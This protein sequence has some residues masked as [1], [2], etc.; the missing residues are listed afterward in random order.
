MSDGPPTGTP[1]RLSPRELEV[2]R[3]VVEGLTNREI[4]VKLFLSERT[5]DG[6]LEHIR[7]KLGV[8]TRAQV[9]AWVVRRDAAPAPAP[10]TPGAPARRRGCGFSH[11][12]AWTAAAL[13]LALLAATVGVLRLTAP[14]PPII[15]T[16]A[17]DCSPGTDP[18]ARA[19]VGDYA[20]AAQA[21]LSRPTSVA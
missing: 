20:P 18:T 16:F 1:P 10:A 15:R 6:H 3:M 8:S 13:V 5:V 11:P 14:P 2:A 4:A 12:R 17:G 19:A 9:T 21:K 7:E